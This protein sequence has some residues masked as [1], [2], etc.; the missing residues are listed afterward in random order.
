MD[1]SAAPLEPQLHVRVTEHHQP[2]G[3]LRLTLQIAAVSCFLQHTPNIIQ[4]AVVSATTTMQPS[5]RQV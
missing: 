4:D 5:G 3:R 2:A 1:Y